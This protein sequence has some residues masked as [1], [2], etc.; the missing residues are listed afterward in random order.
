MNKILE[1]GKRIRAIRE[2]NDLSQQQLGDLVNLSR[3]AITQIEAG[4]RKVCADELV[5]FS[6][7]LSQPIDVILGVREIPDVILPALEKK[8]EEQSSIRID[9]PQKNLSKFKEVLLYLLAKVGSK[10]NVGETVLYK[11]L[12]FIDFNYYERFEEQ[13]IGATYQKNTF[14]PTPIEFQAIAQKM[15][16]DGDM[17]KVRSSY[18]N[19]LQTKYLP[20]KRPDLSKLNARELEVIDDVIA[21]L[22]DLNANQISEYSHQDVPWLT[23]EDGETIKYES[24]FYRTSSY[25]V[26]DYG[27]DI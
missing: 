26:R 23:T 1:V 24:V 2:A 4:D 21:R 7:A 3:V 8:A 22:S 9:V 25:S 15:I 14:G 20:R 16:D 10:P 6:K 12:Y 13:L 27:S 5:S 17:E 18:F 11:L 19:R